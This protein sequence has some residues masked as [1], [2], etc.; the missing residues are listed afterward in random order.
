M[1]ELSKFFAKSEIREF[2]R[3]DIHPAPYNPRGIDDEG[4]RHLKRSLSRFGALGGIVVNTR[5]GNTIV[6]G[7]QKVA[8]MDEAHK[9]D[10]EDP[11]T[12]Y[13]LRAEAIDVDP[14]TER[15]INVALNNPN[16]GGFWDYDK[17]RPLLPDIDWKGAGLTDA[18][19][20]MI[21][22]DFML[23]TEEENGLAGELASLKADVDRPRQTYSPREGDDDDAGG[24]AEG[25]PFQ[26]AAPMTQE[27]KTAHMREVKQQVRQKAMEEA[28][29]MEA[30][31]TLSFSSWEAKADFCRR[32]G[33]APEEKFI[34]G[35]VFGE[36]VEAV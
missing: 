34:K 10:P 20:S 17:L 26:S 2:L 22:V 29:S 30:Y 32:F 35:E 14:Q 13:L 18:D 5:S 11:T 24:D 21:G 9:Y 27:E 28:R 12:D 33:F 6:G 4:R 16:V 7:H 25:E 8:V 3:S 36:M 15:T 31:I 1:A 19:L 23:Q